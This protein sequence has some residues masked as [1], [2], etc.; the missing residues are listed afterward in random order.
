[1]PEEIDH[2][3]RQ[4]PRQLAQRE[5]RA[6]RVG[7]SP[8]ERAAILPCQRFRQCKQAVEQVG[9]G[10]RCRR[11][12]WHAETDFGEQPAER[13]PGNETDPESRADI[14]EQAGA[15]V[16]PDKIGNHRL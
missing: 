6:D 7:T 11:I 1:M 12:E 5:Q 9:T 14:A 10:Q 13:G 16:G 2:R 15:L 8:I 3:N 4:K